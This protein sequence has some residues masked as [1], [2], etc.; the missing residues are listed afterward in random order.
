VWIQKKGNGV[1]YH[2]CGSRRKEMEYAA[3]SVGPEEKIGC[4]LP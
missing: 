3:M 2:E 1:C 4:V